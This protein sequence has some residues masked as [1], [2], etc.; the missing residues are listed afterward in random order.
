MSAGRTDLL[1]RAARWSSLA[2]L[3]LL[4]VACAPA[5]GKRFYTLTYPMPAPVVAHPHAYV[6][7]VKDLAI[8]PTYDGPRLVMRQDTHEIQ[9]STRRRWTERPQRMLG[10]LVRKH[11]RHSGV[12]EQVTERLGERAPDYVLDGQVEAIEELDSGDGLYAHLAMQLRLVRFKDDVVVWRQAFDRRVGVPG[13]SSRAV[14]RGLS[15]IIEEEM[16][17]AVASLDQ[18]FT[19]VAQGGAETP[20]A[21]IEPLPQTEGQGA[22][23]EPLE[24][25]PAPKV[26]GPDSSPLWARHPQLLADDT[27]MPPTRGA[28]FLPALSGGEREP[29]VAAYLDGALAATGRMGQRLALPPGEYELRFGSGTVEQQVSVRARVEEGRVTAVPPTWAVLQVRV[30]NEQFI[31]FRGAYEVIRVANREEYG[32]GFG[33]DEELGEGL[34][35]WVLPPG[36]YKIIRSGGT[37]RDRTNFATVLLEPGEPTRF[38]LVQDPLTGEFRGAGVVEGEKEV[39]DAGPWKLQSVVGGDLGLNRLAQEEGQAEQGWDLDLSVYFDGLARYTKGRH[40]FSTRLEIEES[41]ERAAGESRFQNTT[42]RLYF[43]SIYTFRLLPWF[44]PYARVGLETKI[45][46]RYLDLDAPSTVDELDEDGALRRRHEAVERLELGGPFSPLKLKQGVGG[47]FVVLRNLW[48]DLDLRVGL[49]ARQYFPLGELAAQED[50]G[51]QVVQAVASYHRE[52]PELGVVGTARLSRWIT[53]S[54]E[55]D[56]L[57]PFGQQDDPILEWRSQ[58]SLRLVSFASLNYR[59]NVLRDPVRVA[60]QTSYWEH[61]F[62]LRFS[63]TLF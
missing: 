5:Q 41:Q 33:A 12:F 14:V 32:V 28:V 40:L 23:A 8:S 22:A 51:D 52:G 1:H 10:D 36:L 62:Q 63:Y 54:T 43:H 49:G 47:N 29:L 56:A 13:K 53:L 38:T 59:I 39:A 25:P 48:A 9:F 61:L 6:V 55:L 16:Q 60:G 20:A 2:V 44:G 18:H 35:P 3:A 21:E 45:L 37:Y 50:G 17:Q 30:V 7:R 26:F 24:G 34:R 15:R 19:R 46:P 31:G 4:A 27:P 42:D 58:A 11:L 57:L